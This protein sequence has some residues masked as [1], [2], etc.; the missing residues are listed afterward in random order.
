MQVYY[1]RAAR[2][3]ASLNEGDSVLVRTDKEQT[4]ESAVVMQE[5]ESLQ[6]YLADNA[7]SALRCNRVHL[8]PTITGTRHDA[9]PVGPSTQTQSVAV[10]PLMALC[11][12]GLQTLKCQHRRSFPP[13]VYSC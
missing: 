13:L 5:H 7:Q 6:S 9:E 10:E 11:H 8:Q 12:P 1:D 3:F 4:W 2:E